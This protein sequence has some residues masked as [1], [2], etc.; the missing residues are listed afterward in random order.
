MYIVYYKNTIGVE[1]TNIVFYLDYTCMG[2]YVD[3]ALH[4]PE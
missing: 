1:A 3:E 4:W 2:P